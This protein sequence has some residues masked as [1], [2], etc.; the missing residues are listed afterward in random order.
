[1][2]IRND[3]Y[4]LEVAEGNYVFFREYPPK[5]IDDRAEFVEW[6]DVGSKKTPESIISIFDEFLECCSEVI[7]EPF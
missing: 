2:T 4:E 1:L 5:G 3:E 7:H 6:K